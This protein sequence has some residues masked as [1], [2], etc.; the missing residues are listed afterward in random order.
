MK[1][2]QLIRPDGA[3]PVRAVVPVAG[4]GR[5]E[6]RPVL[7]HD[8]AGHNVLERLLELGQAGQAG[9]N[10]PVGPLVHLG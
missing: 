9:L 3:A 10:H 7:L 8:D 2:I 6:A 5:V 4:G 1:N